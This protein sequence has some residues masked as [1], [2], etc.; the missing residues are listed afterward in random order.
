MNSA[1]V[2]SSLE[3]DDL[4]TPWPAVPQC[5]E[6]ERK[7]G[8]SPE[9]GV[10]PRKGA[11]GGG[12]RRWRLHGSGR[13]RREHGAW[14]LRLSC[15]TATQC[16][17]RSGTCSRAAVE[18]VLEAAAY[19]TVKN[20]SSPRFTTTNFLLSS[21][22]AASVGH[23]RLGDNGG[24]RERCSA[25]KPGVCAGRSEGEGCGGHHW[26]RT[27]NEEDWATRAREDRGEA[28]TEKPYL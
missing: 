13:R 3:C 12:R 14:R 22:L 23:R 4:Q 27:R 10:A 26:H 5:W 28:D 15:T 17:R 8:V 6:R 19:L 18:T 7:G 21:R 1:F 9:K 20:S 2:L 25:R 11:A 16:G 24:M